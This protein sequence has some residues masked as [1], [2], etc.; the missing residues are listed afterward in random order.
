MDMPIPR[1]SCQ[2]PAVPIADLPSI[3]TIILIIIDIKIPMAEKLFF[4]VIYFS[5][6][7]I[8]ELMI[9][10]ANRPIENN[11]AEAIAGSMYL[12]ANRNPNQLPAVVKFINIKFTTVVLLMIKR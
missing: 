4:L 6:P 11:S 12:M 3:T 5:C 8:K 10:I 7:S 9:S 1:L 2:I